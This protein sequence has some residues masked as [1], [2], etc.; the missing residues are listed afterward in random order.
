MYSF[1]F[2]QAFRRGFQQGDELFFSKCMEAASNVIKCV[3]DTLAPS[4]YFRYAPDGH[5]V[6]ASFASAFLLK[7]SLFGRLPSFRRDE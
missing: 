7:V 6:F 3:I 4:G 2:Q 5:F 1:G